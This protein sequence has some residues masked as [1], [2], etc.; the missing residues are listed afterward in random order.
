MP[1]FDEFMHFTRDPT[2]PILDEF[3]RLAAQQG[4]GKKT[5]KKMR[6][7]CLAEEMTDTFAGLDIGG[8]AVYTGSA[9]TAGSD[10]L[11]H[12]QALCAELCMTHIPGS[13]TQCKKALQNTHVNIV[14]LM[15]ARRTGQ[16]VKVFG[17]YAALRNYTFATGRIVS[18]KVAKGKGFGVLLK[19]MS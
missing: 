4:W 13:I 15:D 16:R 3:Y 5:K 7:V 6:Q 10:K 17:S 18:K 14:D 11:H 19:T 2:A 1:F 12:W 9:N 8:V